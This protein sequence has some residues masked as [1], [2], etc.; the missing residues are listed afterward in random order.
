VRIVRHDPVTGRV[1][2]W[3]VQRFGMDEFGEA[4]GIPVPR[5]L[6]FAFS[7]TYRDGVLLFESGR[8]H[9]EITAFPVALSRV[10][11]V[12]RHGA[13]GWEG[14]SF[15]A[16]SSSKR[17]REELRLRTWAMLWPRPGALWSA[18]WRILRSLRRTAAIV[19]SWF[20]KRVT[21][22]D[23]RDL[24]RVVLRFC[25]VAWKLR[26]RGPWM[27]WGLVNAQG[28]FCGVGTLKADVLQVTSP[29]GIQFLS[30]T[31]DQHRRQV[32]ATFGNDGIP[33]P[34][35][36]IPGILL[37]DPVTL[38][39]VAIPY[40]LLTQA[41][42][43]PRTRLPLRVTLDLPAELAITDRRITAVALLDLHPCGE[44]DLPPETIPAWSIWNKLG[45]WRGVG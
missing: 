21:Y 42:F 45:K 34:S 28:S 17:L 13:D 39:P 15:L 10:R 3:G 9:F 25:V 23:V 35:P 32:V 4:I 11:F 29:A 6:L 19:R 22:R 26:L 41:E 37:L 40:S 18:G 12:L 5:R 16:E 36:V 43:D 33:A 14:M 2:A 44:L 38:R 20:P 30:F 7:G 1:A 31:F 8:C 24:A 27:R